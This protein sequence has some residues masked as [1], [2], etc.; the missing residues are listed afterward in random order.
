MMTE[1]AEA[2]R[3]A[4]GEE[5]RF[6]TRLRS[7]AVLTAFATVPRERFVGPGPWRIK[8]PWSLDEYWTTETADPR[9]VYHDVL[10]ALDEAQ[11][12]NNGQ[13]SLWAFLFD[14]LGIAANEHAL[15]LG[16]GAGY[17]TAIIAELVGPQGKVVAIEIDAALAER[18]CAALALWPQV[19]VSN[20]DGSEASL[21][22]ADVIVAS[23]GATHPPL[24]WLAALK[25]G[26]RLLF[27]LT[28]NRGPGRMLLVT[29]ET[30]DGYAAR[31]LC[32]VGF[33]DFRGARDP[34]ASRRLAAALKRDRGMTVKSLRRDDHK[35]DKT[36]WLHGG[37][38]CL[39]RR[40]PAKAEPVAT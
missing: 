11:G 1:S 17:Y 16:C 18:A 30:K 40:D 7:P 6:I 10:I 35:E 8:S 38:W 32:D 12:V 33:I 25:V 4:Y 39:S 36:C 19:A 5:L 21:E 27:P 3:R 34:E 13:P 28:T 24:S 23:A 29:R 20:V 14:K 22:P 31:F 2:A 26:G 37:D 9:S 15:H